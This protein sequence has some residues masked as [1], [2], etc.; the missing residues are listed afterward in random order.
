MKETEGQQSRGNVSD[1]TMLTC[2]L[3]RGL[4]LIFLTLRKSWDLWRDLS[5]I[6]D[7][8]QERFKIKRKFTRE[9]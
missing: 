7:L 3:R 1:F 5:L 8:R 2:S 9:K 6:T 4:S